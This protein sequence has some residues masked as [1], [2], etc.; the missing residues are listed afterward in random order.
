M[1]FPLRIAVVGRSGQVAHALACAADARRV[2]LSARGRPELDLSSID[3]V[4]GFFRD[5]QPTL[6]V[7]A[8]AYTAVD[9]AESEPEAAFAANA[10]APALLATLCNHF[11]LPLIHYSTD[12]VFDGL[13]RTPYTEDDAI[14][15][16][17]VYG[18][19]KAAGEAAVRATCPAHII[20]RTAWVYAPAG[21]NFVRT[22]LRL[23]GDRDVLRVVDDQRGAPTSAI[24]IA[25]ATLDIA[26]RIA[27]GGETAWGTY[28]L[29]ASG[30]TTWHGFAAEIFKLA[31]AGGLKTP[32]L[33]AITTAEYPT[34]ARRPAYSVLGTAK[35]RDLFGIR[36]PE[37]Q[38]SLA[39]DFDEILAQ[40][41]GAK[42]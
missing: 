37:W 13:K 32:R 38:A 6:V 34:P 36:L 24:D 14:D 3:S 20:L 23:G 18:A 19:S 22:M 25:N 42:T 27:S 5:A 12:Y 28:H 9:K 33:E 30:E 40:S 26:E 4:A 16:L 8:A 41:Q 39:R 2:P 10:G 11:K 29:T 31:A 17:G 35:I 15:P 21:A 1:P 7:N